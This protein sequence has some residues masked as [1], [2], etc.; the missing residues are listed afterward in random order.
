MRSKIGCCGGSR[1]VCMCDVRGHGNRALKIG[2]DIYSHGFNEERCLR[3]V[4]DARFRA[5]VI[6]MMIIGRFGVNRNGNDNGDGDVF[7]GLYIHVLQDKIDADND[8]DNDR[9]LDLCVGLYMF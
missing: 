6:V 1:L 7:L 9:L 5:C 4:M 3:R 2:V 8:S